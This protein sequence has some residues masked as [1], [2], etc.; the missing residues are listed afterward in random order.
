MI[1]T[2]HSVFSRVTSRVQYIHKPNI[3]RVCILCMILLCVLLFAPQDFASSFICRRFKSVGF[4]EY[5]NREFRTL[6]VT[7]VP[8]AV[9]IAVMAMQLRYFRPRSSVATSGDQVD[10]QAAIDVYSF[11]PKVFRDTLSK[12]NEVDSEENSDED[13]EG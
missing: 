5:D 6:L 12:L 9:F 8:P 2:R 11:L 4:L 1:S 3:A 10:S 13:I 7:L